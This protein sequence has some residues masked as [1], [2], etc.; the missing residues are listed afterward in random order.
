MTATVELSV[1][2]PA[3]PAETFRAITRTRHLRRWFVDILDYDRSLLTFGAG[4]QLSFIAAEGLIGQGEVTTYRPPEILEY[5][6]DTEVLRF[7]LEGTE[8]THLR[9]INTLEGPDAEDVAEAVR[10]GWE[11]ALERLRGILETG[12]SDE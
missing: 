5:T 11:T 3:T 1:T 10:P 9:F 2:L 12:D 4:R 7:E 6:W 8:S